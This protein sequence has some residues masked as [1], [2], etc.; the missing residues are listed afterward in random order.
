MEQVYIPCFS[1][2]EQNQEIQRTMAHV[3]LFETVD[4]L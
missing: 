2:K 3:K 4:S 1:V